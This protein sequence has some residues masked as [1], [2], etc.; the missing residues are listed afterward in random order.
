MVK[1]KGCKICSQF[2][3]KEYAYQ[4][5]GWEDR[6]SYISGDTDQLTLIKD[7]NTTYSSRLL[8]I[9]Q[10][11][12]CKAYFLYRTDYEYCVAGSEDEQFLI[13]LSDEKVK[14]Y[15]KSKV[16]K[17]QALKYFEEDR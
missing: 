3:N 6:N 1:N 2:S 9:L 16:T 15:L 13:Q 5:H 8:Q 4:K 17:L 11:P 7:F 12:E 14:K 10:C